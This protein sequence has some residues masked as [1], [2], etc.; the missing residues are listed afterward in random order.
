MAKYRSSG[1]KLDTKNCSHG[2]KL[3]DTKMR[4]EI[5]LEEM[6]HQTLSLVRAL[7]CSISPNFRMIMLE[8][9]NGLWRID[10]ILERDSPSEREL[11]EDIQDEFFALQKTN[12]DCETRIEINEGEIPWPTESLTKRVV[13]RRMEKEWRDGEWWPIEK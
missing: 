7:F 1:T 3:V 6:N 2:T 4:N 8:Y 9:D 5:S 13:Y 11:I 12:I 10:F